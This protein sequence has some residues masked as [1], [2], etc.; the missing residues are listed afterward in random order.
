MRLRNCIYYLREAGLGVWRN[1]WMTLASVTVVVLTLL[2][3]GSFIAI[4]LNIVQITEG[5]KSQVEVIAYLKDD[6][7]V[8]DLRQ[9]I[10]DLP[11]IG[12]LSYITKEQALERMRE[13]LGEGITAALDDR[14][15]LPASFEIKA[16]NPDHIPGLAETIQQLAGVESVD[17]GQEVVE[18]LFQ[19]T[20]VLQLFG[21]G[22]IAALAIM[23]L[24]LI[25]NT[26]KLTVYARRKQISIMKFVGA[27]DWFIRWP[28]ILEGVFLGLLGALTAYLILFFGYSFFYMQTSAWMYQNFLSVAMATPEQ[29]GM[30]LLKMLFALGAGIGAVGSGIS[31]RKFLKV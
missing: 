27:T 14:N 5:I 22:I 16:V 19:F 24:F 20:R 15:P 26:I 8:E 3:L 1:G 13:Q 12:Q 31:V 7:E 2:I 11:G 6:A 10:L 25:A 9:K 18:K 23:A 4:N 29:V 17:Y 28:F 21:L 30:E